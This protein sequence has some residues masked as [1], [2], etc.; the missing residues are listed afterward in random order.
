[1]IWFPGRR[2][3]AQGYDECTHLGV[4][5]I[6]TSTVT[7]LLRWAAFVRQG[8]SRF[9]HV[10]IQKKDMMK[11][12]ENKFTLLEVVIA[13]A[14]LCG[15]MAVVF[16]MQANAKN[17]FIRSRDRWAAVHSLTNVVEMVLLTGEETPTAM[18]DG[19]VEDGLRVE[20]S[21]VSPVEF[22]LDENINLE[23]N[24]FVLVPRHAVARSVENER[25]LLDF[26]FIQ[27]LEGER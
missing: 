9:H 10:G 2:T 22:G 17:R 6:G 20:F 8:Q 5:G 15:A 25:P 13:M 19:L 4:L 12:R 3:F 14:I 18:A 23:L 11:E 1:L 24:G 27:I 7:I 26:W 16:A 21:T